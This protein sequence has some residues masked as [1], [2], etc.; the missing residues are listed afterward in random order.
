[1]NMEADPTVTCA[2]LVLVQTNRQTGSANA[3][4]APKQVN[5]ISKRASNDFLSRSSF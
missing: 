5:C 4:H 2:L 1:M 3:G